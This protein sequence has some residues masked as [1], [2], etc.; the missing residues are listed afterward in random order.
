MILEPKK[1]KSLTVSIVYPSIY[2]EVMG[3]ELMGMSGSV[4]Y[5]VTAPIS[6]VLVCMHKVLF[7]PSKSL[8]PQ[9]CVSSDGSMVEIM[10][11]SFKWAYAISRSAAPRAPAA[12]HC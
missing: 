12:D 4:S 3:P 7:V 11:T 6:W 9:S 5:G 1:I 10:V 2:H 8:F